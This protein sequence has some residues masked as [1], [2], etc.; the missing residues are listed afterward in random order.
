MKNIL[1]LHG[2]NYK[3]YTSLT[4]EKDAWHN[5]ESFVNEL[6]KKYNIYKLNFPGFCSC[7]EP[8]EKSWD[9]DDYAK[10]VNDYINNNNLKI[11][12]IIGYSFGGAVAVR[13]KKIFNNDIK[14]ILISP[15]LIRNLNKSK[16]FIKTPKI[17]NPI[18]KLLRNIYLIRVVKNNEMIY[19]TKFLRNSYQSIVRE[20]TLI[21]INEFNSKDILIIY[22]GKDNMVNPSK[23]IETIDDKF[24]NNIIIIKDGSH[25][26]ANTHTNE[27]VTIINKHIK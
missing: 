8:N 2:W 21:D 7:I 6:S 17:F 9:L 25:D 1:L 14:E 24:K 23:V 19:G 16:K 18:R 3:N 4:K 15:A 5:R 12:Y 27:L 22:G 20:N 11:D 13:Y 10:Y 26:I